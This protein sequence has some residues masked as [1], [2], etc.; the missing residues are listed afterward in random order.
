MDHLL[1]SAVLVATVFLWEA[2][3]AAEKW[4]KARGGSSTDGRSE[5][6]DKANKATQKSDSD[7]IASN[8]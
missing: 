4:A 2:Q 6:R 8:N 5:K 3:V 7:V 1:M